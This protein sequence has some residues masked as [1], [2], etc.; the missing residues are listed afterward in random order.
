MSNEQPAANGA[1]PAAAA[2]VR[3]GHGAQ[4]RFR[5][6]AALLVSFTSWMVQ[7]Y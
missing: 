3:S 4:H 2:T 5:H 1:E 6:A 7:V